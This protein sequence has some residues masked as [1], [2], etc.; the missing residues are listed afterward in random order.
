VTA[1]RRLAV[2]ALLVVAVACHSGRSYRDPASPRHAGAPPGE[3]PVASPRPDTLLVVSFNIE[4]ARRVSGAIAL[5]TSDSALR[6]VDLLLLQEM[7]AEGTRR[8]AEALGLRYVYYP[9]VWHGRA[10]RDVGNAILSR[11]PVVADEKLILP[12]V[13]RYAGTQRTATAATVQV[14]DALVCVYSTHLGTPLDVSARSRRAQLAAVL[15]DAARYEHVILGG[16]LNDT[17]VGAAAREAGYGWPTERGPRTTLLG[18]YD[19]IF[20]RGLESP[21]E[22]AAGTVPDARGTSD[23]L[24]VWVR[25]VLR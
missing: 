23:H 10:R 2:A 22:G 25:A 19:H 4:F 21:A 24:P 11:W 14:G 6:G 13:S 18:R 8:I 3:A 20:L 9:S 17:R 16:D 7:D 1:P 5:L 15:A 12:H